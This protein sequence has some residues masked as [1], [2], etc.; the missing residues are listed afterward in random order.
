MEKQA[1]INSIASALHN[2]F[3]PYWAAAMF[4]LGLLG[5][6]TTWKYWGSFWNGYVL[7]ITGP[8]WNY[9]L[10]RGLF[11]GYTE[12]KWRNIFSSSR[13][14]ILFASVCIGIETAQYF[15]WYDATFDWFDLIAYFALLLPLYILDRIQQ[16]TKMNSK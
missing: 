16:S 1:H 3:A 7:D 14:F 4:L 2:R 6:S 8:A 15:N 5:I 13:T 12:N 10:F 9:I 11:T